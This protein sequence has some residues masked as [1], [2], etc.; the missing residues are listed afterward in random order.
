MIAAEHQG[1]GCGRLAIEALTNL[2]AAQGCTEIM[3]GYANDNEIA[4]SLYQRVGFVE[5]GLDDEGDMVS[6]LTL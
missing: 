6:R 3:V 4:R 5:L 1:K 2:M